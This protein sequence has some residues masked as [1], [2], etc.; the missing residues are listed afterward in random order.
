MP[1]L[2]I[3]SLL[4]GVLLAFGYRV[5]GD[6]LKINNP[7]YK[8]ITYGACVFL[9]FFMIH[10][11]FHYQFIEFDTIIM[12]GGEIHYFLSLVIGGMIIGLLNNK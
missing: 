5:F 7:A 3:T 10:E 12:I 4:W 1:G 2:L 8:G 6:V 9:F 11:F